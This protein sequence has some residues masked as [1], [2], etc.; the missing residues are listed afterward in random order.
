[1]NCTSCGE[2]VTGNFCDACGA[3]VE[4]QPPPELADAVQPQTAARAPAWPSAPTTS[5]ASTAAR[6]VPS[7]PALG[8]AVTAGAAGIAAA[9]RLPNSPVLLCQNEHVLRVYRAVQLR[10]A[11]RGEGTLFVTDARLVFYARAEG[12]GAQ[13]ESAIVQQTK[14][15]DITG[16]SAFVSR[17]ISLLLLILIVLFGLGAI[18]SLLARDVIGI[19]FCLAVVAVCLIAMS[20]GS[21]QRG[22][23]GVTIHSQA[24]QASPIGFGTWSEYRNPLA[25]LLS[26]MLNPLLIFMRSQT[27]FDVLVGRPGLDSDLLISELGALILDLQTR[28]TLSLD[29][30]GEVGGQVPA[31]R[32]ATT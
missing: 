25:T 19:I 17:R 2:V 27:A 15:Q 3:A 28:G 26:A 5:A 23:A 16:M 24:T 32:S 6:P 29:H 11:K 14:L 12:R 21:A 30:W 10:S 13:R 9:G 31:Q 8:T 1:M 20:G 18:G 22:R 7:T 4:T